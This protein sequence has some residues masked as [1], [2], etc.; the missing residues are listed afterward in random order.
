MMVLCQDQNAV[1]A[2]L[3]LG[4]RVF[5]EDTRTRPSELDSGTIVRLGN[6]TVDIHCEATPPQGDTPGYEEETLCYELQDLQF[7]EEVPELGTE[8]TNKNKEELS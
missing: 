7:Y 8:G 2:A 1:K 6:G 4:Q 5:F 3:T